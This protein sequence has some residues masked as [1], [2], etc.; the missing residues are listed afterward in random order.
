MWLCYSSRMRTVF[1]LMVFGLPRLD[2]M[3]DHSSWRLPARPSDQ[4]HG[5]RLVS[6]SS[7]TSTMRWPHVFPSSATAN[8]IGKPTKSRLTPT[9]IGIHLRRRS[10]K[11]SQIRLPYPKPQKSALSPL[12]HHLRSRKKPSL[13]H[14]HQ[15]LLRPQPFPRWQFC[16]NLPPHLKLWFPPLLLLLHHP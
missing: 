1:L 10:N 8:W 16:I 15:F 13:H 11:K 14:H 6:L 7:A 2:H 4:R 12:P 9:P 3:H 5:A